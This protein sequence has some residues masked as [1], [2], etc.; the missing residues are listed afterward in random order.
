M[1]RIPSPGTITLQLADEVSDNISNTSMS[2]APNV[3]DVPKRPKRLGKRER[4]K[5]KAQESRSFEVRQN[6][7]NKL[8]N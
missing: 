5:K 1:V 2:D 7:S 8:V 3:V 4:R 6:K